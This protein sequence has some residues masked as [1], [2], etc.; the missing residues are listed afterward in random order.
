MTPPFPPKSLLIEV[1]TIRVPAAAAA[2]ATLPYRAR[3]AFGVGIR[4]RR[5]ASRY[6]FPECD[7]RRG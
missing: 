4:W 5:I 1:S 3:A 7:E 6:P 2:A